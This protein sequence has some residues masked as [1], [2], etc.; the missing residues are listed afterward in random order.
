MVTPPF[1][2]PT[3]SWTASPRWH[4]VSERRRT[5]FRL[6]RALLLMITAAQII[7]AIL[8]AVRRPPHNR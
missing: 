5:V 7:L 3:A 8:F 2:G 6:G 4:D 1:G